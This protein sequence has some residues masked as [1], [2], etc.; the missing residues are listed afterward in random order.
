[1]IYLSTV[2]EVV[3]GGDLVFAV[4]ETGACSAYFR[5]NLQIYSCLNNFHIYQV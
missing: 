1:M 5:S 2:L 3:S 4:T